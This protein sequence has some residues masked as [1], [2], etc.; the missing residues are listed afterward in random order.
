MKKVR[1]IVRLRQGVLDPQ[2]KTAEHALHSLGFEEVR[3]VRIGKYIELELDE[4]LEAD[5][6]H[7][8]VKEMCDKL[9]A[10]PVIEDYEI[11]EG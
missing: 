7:E 10:N 6:L 4:T 2:G 9:L 1:V 5:K 3:D 11:V 8:H